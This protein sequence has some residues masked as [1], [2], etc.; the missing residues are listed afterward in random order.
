MSQKSKTIQVIPLKEK[1]VL[2][3]NIKE[4]DIAKKEIF[5]SVM[6]KGELSDKEDTSNFIKI[7]KT[8]TK[9]SEDRVLIY[10]KLKNISGR[11]I[12][13]EGVLHKVKYDGEEVTVTPTASTVLQPDEEG[14]VTETIFLGEKLSDEYIESIKDPV[15]TIAGIFDE[16]KLEILEPD[17]S[18]KF[19]SMENT[20][21][22]ASPYFKFKD[23]ELKTND[24]GSM[25]LYGKPKDV[26][27]EKYLITGTLALLDPQGNVID[28]VNVTLKNDENGGVYVHG[29][30]NHADGSQYNNIQEIKSFLIKEKTDYIILDE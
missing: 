13:P 26:D 20:K 27:L 22:N 3:K 2:D 16:T 14:Y 28:I 10:T 18:T 8:E 29:F 19:S 15:K 9:L 6:S 30:L 25:Y 17:T 21:K 11:I 5:L 1:I 4:D 23:F 7:L 12:Y 24:S